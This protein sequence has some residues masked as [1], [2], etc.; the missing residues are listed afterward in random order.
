ADAALCPLHDFTMLRFL[1][2]ALSLFSLAL[3]SIALAANP[4]AKPD[5][6]D[7]RLGP[8]FEKRERPTLGVDTAPIVV[9]EFASYKCSHCYEFLQRTMPDIYEK[10]IKTGKV[11]WFLVPSSDDPADPSSKIFTVGR[12]V[13]RQGKFW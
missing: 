10:Y 3:A 2:S 9:I 5:A 13:L 6:S 4:P 8:P 11:Q 1:L 12:C 7:P